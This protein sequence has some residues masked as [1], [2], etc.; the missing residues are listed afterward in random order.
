MLHHRCCPSGHRPSHFGRRVRTSSSVMPLAA[1]FSGSTSIRTARFCCPPISTCA[2]PGSA[3]SAA[4]ARSRHSHRGRSAASPSDCAARIMIGASDGFTFRYVGGPGMVF[5]NWPLASPEWPPGCRPPRHR[6]CGPRSNCT[7]TLVVPR[8]LDD[9]SCDTP[10]IWAIWVSSGC[11]TVAAMVSGLA[12]GNCPVTTMVGK[13]TQWQRGYRQQRIGGDAHQHQGGHH[14]GC[15]D[16][17]FDEGGGDA[18]AA[19]S[20]R[21]AP[22]PARLASWR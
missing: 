3:K 7:V 16:R 2:T 12:P 14:Q 10:G 20:R 11:A 21:S 17:P 18:H 19:F 8:M 9:V 1:I 5:G 13:S 15:R 6:C 4:T 22:A